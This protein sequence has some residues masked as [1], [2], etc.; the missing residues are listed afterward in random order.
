VGISKN[1][2]WS[3]YLK[4][5]RE[6]VITGATVQIN[7]RKLGYDAVGTLMLDIEPSQLEELSR[8]IATRVPE[9]FGPFF[10]ASKF[11]AGAVV[12]LRNVSELGKIKEEL[13]RKLIVT[14]ISSS[15]WTD[16]WFVPENLSLIP[17]RSANIT[18]LKTEDNSVFH[19]DKIDLHLI[20]ALAK[21]SR[22]SFRA[23]AIQL[24]V[25]IDTVAR[26][27]R[28]LKEEK[29]IVPRIQIDPRKIGY[30]ALVN[31]YLKIMPQFDVDVILNELLQFSDA[32]YVMKFRGD[33]SV[34]MML[35]VKSIQDMLETGDHIARITGVKRTETVVSSVT[36]KW[37]L[38]R[39]YTSTL[40][41]N[42]TAT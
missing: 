32:F 29:V 31:F 35:M 23:L 14:E 4:M 21:D 22:T 42:T 19:A 18:N 30:N 2:A 33:F 11:N 38:P 9:A 40:G 34:G 36:D 12:P 17:V 5:N 13:S 27:Y 28:R 10:S 6:G 3:R 39:T 37:P 41:R 25:S 1:A 20:E 24:G 7:Y 8:Y 16:V 15:L 26:R